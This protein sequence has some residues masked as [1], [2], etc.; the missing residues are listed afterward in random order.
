MQ[1]NI[2]IMQDNGFINDDG[3]SN[4]DHH[5][6]VEK[7]SG[8]LSNGLKVGCG[9]ILGVVFTCMIGFFWSVGPTER[10]T[11]GKGYP[12]LTDGLEEYAEPERP[13]QYFQVRSKKGK[14]TI[15]TGMP[16][17]SVILLL[18]QPTEFISRDYI[19]QITYR[20][21]SYDLNYLQ[22]EFEDGRISSVSQ[23]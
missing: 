8:C 3:R 7:K 14:A 21:G 1:K 18:G 20:Y 23:H 4:Y 22:I 13:V 12:S 5:V 16:K 2:K 15:H 9:F 6:Y 17:D 11:D 19:D 10:I